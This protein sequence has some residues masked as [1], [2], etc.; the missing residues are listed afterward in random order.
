M[1]KKLRT[2]CPPSSERKGKK[3][4]APKARQLFNARAQAPEPPMGDDPA[5][6]SSAPG[7]FIP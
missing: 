4:Q 5:S 1:A 2:P 3:R 6:S 7:V